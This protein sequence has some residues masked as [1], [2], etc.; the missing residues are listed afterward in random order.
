LADAFKRNLKA[1]RNLLSPLLVTPRKIPYVG[2]A[3][4]VSFNTMKAMIPTEQ[5]SSQLKDAA[6]AT[7]DQAEVVVDE[8]VMRNDKPKPVT[9]KIRAIVTNSYAAGDDVLVGK[10]AMRAHLIKILILLDDI[11]GVTAK[12][13]GY[14]NYEEGTKSSLV[15]PNEELK[16]FLKERGALVEAIFSSNGMYENDINKHVKDMRGLHNVPLIFGLLKPPTVDSRFETPRISGQNLL[17]AATVI[18][19]A[20]DRIDNSYTFKKVK[21]WLQAMII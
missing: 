17:D 12:K 16:L 11:C 4:F 3:G 5:R 7:K 18:K 19:E 9:R 8:T 20:K 1:L 15:E 2:G 14:F 10:E 6:D 13:V 21:T